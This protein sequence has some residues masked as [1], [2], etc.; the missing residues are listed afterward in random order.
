[1]KC[2]SGSVMIGDNTHHLTPGADEIPVS[3][4]PLLLFVVE[5]VSMLK[6]PPNEHTYLYVIKLEGGTVGRFKLDSWHDKTHKS[7]SSEYPINREMKA[8][9]LDHL[10][11]CFLTLYRLEPLANTF[12]NR[13]QAL[14][15]LQSTSFDQYEAIPEH[16]KVTS[17]WHGSM[18]IVSVTRLFALFFPKLKHVDESIGEED[19]FNIWFVS[20]G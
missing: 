15:I 4:A 12:K 9:H 19:H 18:P 3:D 1:M 20:V 11:N 17:F 8:H 5:L 7:G 13:E 16:Q 10:Q 2:H 14:E 6:S